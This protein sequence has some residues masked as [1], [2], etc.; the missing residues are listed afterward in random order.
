MDTF[1]FAVSS[2]EGNCT[3]TDTDWECR[4]GDQNMSYAVFRDT[5]GYDQQICEGA[6]SETCEP[7]ITDQ[8]DIASEPDIRLLAVPN[9]FSGQTV[10]HIGMSADSHA[11]V[12][13]FDMNGRAVILHDHVANRSDQR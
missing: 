3:Y 9:P 12:A 11:S 8:D 6:Y 5:T 1:N 7:L 4:Y 13:I 2:I 10:I